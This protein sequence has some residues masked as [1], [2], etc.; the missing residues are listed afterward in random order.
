MVKRE[1]APAP[2]ATIT[3]ATSP[4]IVI[5][6]ISSPNSR[7][8][9]AAPGRMAWAMASPARLMRRSIRKTPTGQE[10]S[11]SISEP[12]RARCMKPIFDEGR[13]QVIVDHHATR[14]WSWAMVVS[15]VM[16]VVVLIRFAPRRV[17]APGLL[18]AGAP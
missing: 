14:E 10:P 15:V 18:E 4:P 7:K 9:A 5:G 11:D 3:P 13:D 8:P 16:T 1:T 17:V 6:T 12:A 2:S